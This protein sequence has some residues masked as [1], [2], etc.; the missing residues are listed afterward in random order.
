[1]KV[2]VKVTFTSSKEGSSSL[3]IV[4][5]EADTVAS[6]KERVAALQLIPFP[7]QDLKLHGEALADMGRL[8][9]LGVK[10]QSTLDLE[11]K[12]SEETLA[13]QLRE[14]LQARDLSCDELGLMY[15]YKHGASITQALKSLGFTKDKLQDFIR[16]QKAFQLNG[17]TVALVRQDTA[18][19]P[20]SVAEEVEAIL[21]ASS[22]GVLDIK[23]LCSRFVAKYNISL[24]SIACARPLDFLSRDSRFIITDRRLV[25]LRSAGPLKQRACQQAQSGGP[26]SVAPVRSVAEPPAAGPPAGRGALPGVAPSPPAEVSTAAEGPAA[27][28]DNQQFLDLHNRICSRQFFSKSKQAL[29]DLADDL[30]QA[31]FLNV[32]HVVNAG[33][34][35]KGTAIGGSADAELVFFLKDLPSGLNGSWIPPLLCAVASVFTLKLGEESGVEAVTTGKDSVRLRTKSLNTVD[36]RFSPTLGSHADVVQAMGTLEP[37]ARRLYGAALME[38][39]VQFI[40]R[41]P[42]AVK[43]TIRLLKWWRDQQSWSSELV[44]PSDDILE[45]VAVYAAVKGKPADQRSAIAGVMKL[46]ARFNELRIVWSNYYTKADVWA[47]LIRQQPLLMDP[48]NPFMNMADPEVFDACELMALAGTSHFFR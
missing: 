34:V 19:R 3:E 14:L 8:S 46:L 48:V 30:Q 1:M 35:G 4:V 16:R 18:L 37:E 26:V 13:Q 47:P 44:R 20:L 39:R 41:Q 43:I 32:D 9:D 45:L 27:S 15:S 31:I 12:A 22:S 24:A 6:V 40:A 17:S 11:V 33:A 23:E 25:S 28:V 7:D 38:E 36:I 42:V 10:E 21:K 5:G 29:T 2:Q